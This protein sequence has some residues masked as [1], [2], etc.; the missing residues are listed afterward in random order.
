MNKKV[1]FL[2]IS[3]L[4][5]YQ[6][7]TKYMYEKYFVYSINRHQEIKWLLNRLGFRRKDDFIRCLNYL[8]KYIEMKTKKIVFRYKNELYIRLFKKTYLRIKNFNVN[9]INLKEKI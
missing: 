9:I 8:R 6:L 3:E 5:A 1:S 2:K 7:I 4:E